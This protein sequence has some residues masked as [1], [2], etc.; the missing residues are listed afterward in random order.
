MSV[1]RTP[2]G[3]AGIV[4]YA[5]PSLLM[6]AGEATFDPKI[7][8]NLIISGANQRLQL[9]YFTALRT[10]TCTQFGVN[11]GGTAA[12]ATPTLCRIGL[13]TVDGS[14]NLTLVAATNND[15]TLFAGANTRYTKPASASYSK[16][17]GQRYATGVLVVTAATAPTFCGTASMGGSGLSQSTLPRRQGRVAGVSDLPATITAATVTVDGNS[18]YVELLA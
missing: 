17:A 16:V 15:T 11:T 7:A 2:A 13:Y 10:E 14:D 18:M 3:A 6:P 5:Q 12:G 1:L 8:T 4:P 9:T